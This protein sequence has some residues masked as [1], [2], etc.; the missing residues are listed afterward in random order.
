MELFSPLVGFVCGLLLSV[1]P[2]GPEMGRVRLLFCLALLFVLVCLVL[3]FVFAVCFYCFGESC[4]SLKLGVP[5][6][7]IALLILDEEASGLSIL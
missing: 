6:N 7:F 2:K 4:R 1:A 3:V 5:P